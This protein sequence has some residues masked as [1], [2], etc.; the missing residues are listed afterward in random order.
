[1]L[2][3]AGWGLRHPVE[4]RVLIQG[5]GSRLGSEAAVPLHLSVVPPEVFKG[6]D[7]PALLPAP[8]LLASM[9][10][11]LNCLLCAWLPKPLRKLSLISVPLLVCSSFKSSPDNSGTNPEL[12]ARIR[13]GIE[14]KGSFHRNIFLCCSGNWRPNSEW[15]PRS[16]CQV[17]CAMLGS[18]LVPWMTGYLYNYY[19]KLRVP[20]RN[21]RNDL[22]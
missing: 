4:D 10:S 18:H 3:N 9:W 11:F 22:K 7:M 12:R 13:V 2:T 20:Q 6:T 19:I 8:P 17:T 1:M 5:E 15:N 14:Q 16:T 21:R